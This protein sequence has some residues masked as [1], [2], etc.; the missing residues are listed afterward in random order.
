MKYL[1]LLFALALPLAAQNPVTFRNPLIIGGT[2]TGMN[3]QGGTLG[4][5]YKFNGVA[6]GTGSNLITLTVGT[7][8]VTFTKTGTAAMLSDLST[9]SGTASS[10]PILSPNIT[11]SSL[12]TFGTGATMTG[13]ASVAL[14]SL[15]SAASVPLGGI[16][17]IGA[18]GTAALAIAVNT[19]GGVMTNGTGITVTIGGIELGHASDTTIARS[20]A[21]IVTIE[22][23]A[24]AKMYAA[25]TGNL[26][27]SGG[28]QGG[29]T[30][31]DGYFL[32]YKADGSAF[33]STRW[34][35]GN[36]Q[37]YL[38]SG[39]NDLVLRFPSPTGNRQI[40][41]PDATGTAA[42]V[43]GNIGNATGT[44]AAALVSLGSAASVPATGITGTGGTL[45][46]AQIATSTATN[47]TLG[48]GTTALAGSIMGGSAGVITGTGSVLTANNLTLGTGTTNV[49]G[50]GIA[51]G[52]GGITM[53]G[54][55]GNRVAFAS[56]TNPLLHYGWVGQ[57]GSGNPRVG[58]GTAGS[59]L[60]VT[61]AGGT[62][63]SVST[64]FS[65]SSGTFTVGA[66][67]P[68]I[69]GGTTTAAGVLTHIGTSATLGS[70]ALTV[71]GSGT[72]GT[73]T[74]KLGTAGTTMT[75]IRH[76]IAPA[77][78]LGT[79]TVADVGNTVNSRYFFTT[80]TLGTILR[81]VSY[82]RSTGTAGTGFTIL[83]QDATDTSIVIWKAVE[84]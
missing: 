14:V 67:Q 59:T 12:K 20:A 60:G 24:I 17:G 80:G 7:T 78:V 27:V 62:T 33:L 63:I 46:S 1:A 2:G 64:A 41:L 43:N 70:T 19:T 52:T 50:S 18:G 31:E 21:G 3:I 39:T 71:T 11:A 53:H 8:G 28:F 13:T 58:L 81:P 32:T 10:G 23:Q 69:F 37:L 79:G 40:W 83:S 30:G 36:A 42:L 51:M 54:S 66:G 35:S 16:T 15:G 48:T 65:V 29:G 57:D 4:A 25:N 26:N 56:A 75:N 22:G 76:G 45:T 47:L 73:A 77:L 34:I 49:F 72:A 5:I 74:I 6:I 9:G 84:P 55:G 68:A 61:G 38:S 82:M 44:A